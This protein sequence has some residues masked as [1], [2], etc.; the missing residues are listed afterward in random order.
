L[1]L[2]RA[3]SANAEGTIS[4]FPGPWYWHQ[5]PSGGSVA[6]LSRNNA[7]I[8]AMATK[9]LSL[10]IPFQ[11]LGR[12][13]NR[14]VVALAKKILP[15]NGEPHEFIESVNSWKENETLTAETSG[16][17]SRLESITDRAECL[18]NII[19]EISPTS[20]EEVLNALEE[21]FSETNPKI[22]LST[23]HRAKG[24]E[25]DTVVHLDPW[26]IPSFFASSADARQQ[27]ANILNVLE[28]RT[29]LHFI[30]A[31]LKHFMGK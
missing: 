25:Y 27:E 8:Y 16:K 10:R 18:L 31:N 2:F 17:H 14:P 24:L 6:I 26:R 22:I 30:T 28:T 21:I 12:E 4:E 7:P 13:G 3:A 11:I 9:L 19:A 1:P 5:I 15:K 23:V 29:K 20:R